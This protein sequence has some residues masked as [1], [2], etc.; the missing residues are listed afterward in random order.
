MAQVKSYRNAS[1]LKCDKVEKEMVSIGPMIFCKKCSDEEFKDVITAEMGT[2]IK[3]PLC[4]WVDPQ[5]PKYSKW[6]KEYQGE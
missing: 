5:N 3:Q 1:C 6:L 2:F 4:Y